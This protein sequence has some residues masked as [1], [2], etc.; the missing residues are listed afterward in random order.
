M[1]Y[2]WCKELGIL[3]KANKIKLAAASKLREGSIEILKG[4]DKYKSSSSIE[5]LKVGSRLLKQHIRD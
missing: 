2:N 1:L 5:D 3:V 4:V